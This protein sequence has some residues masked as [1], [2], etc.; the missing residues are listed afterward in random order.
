MIWSYGVCTSLPLSLSL[1][2]CWCLV[3]KCLTI[4]MCIL[5]NWLVPWSSFWTLTYLSWEWM[6]QK[7]PVNILTFSLLNTKSYGLW[8]M[9]YHVALGYLIVNNISPSKMNK[10]AIFNS[11]FPDDCLFMHEVN[12]CGCT[13]EIELNHKTPIEKGNFWKKQTKWFARL[14][15]IIFT[16]FELL[17]V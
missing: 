5:L 2:E 16:L 9:V 3:G 11:I 13:N 17:K 6:Q 7:W 8:F 15:V 14:K 4:H 1:Y 12:T 10:I